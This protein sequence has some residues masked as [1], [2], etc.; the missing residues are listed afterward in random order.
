M[1][2]EDL[3]RYQYYEDGNAVNMVEGLSKR[4]FEEYRW[5]ENEDCLRVITAIK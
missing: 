1:Y 2:C 3:T 4:D 5:V